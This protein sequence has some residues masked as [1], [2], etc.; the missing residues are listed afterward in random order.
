MVSMVREIVPNEAVVAA[1][2][3]NELVLLDIET[4]IYFGLDA[5]GARVWQMLT[6]GRARDEIVA[7]LLQE[8]EVEEEQL[9]GDLEILLSQLAERGLVQLLD[10]EV[11]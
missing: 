9:R 3:G 1:D 11:R 7:N 8:Y 10:G 2:V 6:D 5:V 4:G